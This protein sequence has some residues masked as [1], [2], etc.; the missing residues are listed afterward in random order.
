MISRAGSPWT[1]FFV[2]VLLLSS[3]A[4]S[5]FPADD[6]KLNLN[7]VRVDN[8]SSFILSFDI[9]NGSNIAAAALA[10]GRIHIWDLTTGQFLHEIV[11]TPPQTDDGMKVP[12]EV[13]PISLHFSPDG[14]SLGV[15]FLN[16]ICIYDVSNWSETATLG[17]AGEELQ[18]ADPKNVPSTPQLQ[19]RSSADAEANKS[20][21]DLSLNDKMRAWAAAKARGDGVTRITD[22][23]FTIDGNSI[24]AAYCRGECYASPSFRSVPFPTGND[25]VRLWNID[26]KRLLWEVAYGQQSAVDEIIP[27]PDGIRFAAV[28]ARPGRCAV[29]MHNVN[30]GAILWIHE[31]ANCS[32]PPGVQ[33]S[34]DGRSFITNRLGEGEPKD[35]LW[36]KAAIYESSSGE[37]LG[38]FSRG[39]TVRNSDM[40]LDGRWFAVTTWDGYHFQIWDRSS[41]KPLAMGTPKEWRWGGP[42]MNRIRFSP[43]GRW[44][45][46]GNNKAGILI[47]YRLSPK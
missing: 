29:A 14:K 2:V 20:K 24:I 22:F 25:P 6:G 32:D 28:H 47:V 15:S 39:S 37:L 42:P 30:D 27:S 36:R 23:A 44:L 16:R 45:V 10:E 7:E 41:G 4:A 5:S 12:G 21:P 3:K 17:V 19:R 8:L 38:D 1:A 13:E 9:A 18:R 33:F 43:D 31:F 35:K 26:S 11:L 34:R 46:V 40:S